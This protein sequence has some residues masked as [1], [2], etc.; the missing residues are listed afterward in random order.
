ML[1]V[2]KLQ[3]HVA[4]NQ[5]FNLILL[6]ASLISLGSTFHNAAVDV[7]INL[8]PNRIVLLRCGTSE[9][10]DAER[11]ALAGECQ[12]TRSIMHCGAS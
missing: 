7:S 3:T 11:S 5:L 1:K 2:T 8:L 4:F 6:V 9:V 12:W 10:D